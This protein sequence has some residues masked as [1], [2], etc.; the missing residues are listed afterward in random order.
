MGG[1]GGGG[2]HKRLFEL[3]ACNKPAT[4]YC[5]SVIKIKNG[6]KNVYFYIN[7]IRS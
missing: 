1:G 3:L 2:R 5:Y 7:V 4:V 6:F